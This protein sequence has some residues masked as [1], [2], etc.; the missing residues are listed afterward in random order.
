MTAFD[1]FLMILAFGGLSTGG[2]ALS[3][4]KELRRAIEGLRAELR[5]DRPAP[6]AT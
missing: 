3:Q 1:V 4:V 5:R 2:Q 6:P